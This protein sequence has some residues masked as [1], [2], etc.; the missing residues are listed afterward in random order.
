MRYAAAYLLARLGGNAS[1]DVAD[2]TKILASV[3]ILCDKDRAE[4][5]I[6][7]C[8][9]R[10]VEEIIAGGMTKLSGM[11]TNTSSETIEQT[12]STQPSVGNQTSSTG[13]ADKPS[14]PSRPD[15]PVDD[16]TFAS[17]FD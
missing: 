11:V 9:G 7:A 16:D 2:I 4:Q 12:S 1:P 3:G 14:P 6:D 17:L 13:G 5:V 10:D 15:S 8:K